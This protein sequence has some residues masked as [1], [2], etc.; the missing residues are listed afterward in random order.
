MAFHYRFQH[1]VFPTATLLTVLFSACK[2][3]IPVDANTSLLASHPWRISA[4]ADT[5]NTVKPPETVDVFVSFPIYR[6]DDTYRFNTDNSL[7]FDE[8]SLK[9]NAADA[10][11]T[12]GKWQFQNEQ[13][14][15][16]ITLNKTVALGTTGITSSSTYSIL[17]LRGD[18]LRLTHGT[19]A[20]TVVVTLTR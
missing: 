13:K 7:I 9:E 10:Q 5:D 15:L 4:F 20:Q 8:G 6:R 2:K 17:K 14:S 12:A 3:D 1:L 19:Q 18:T 16:T 11:N